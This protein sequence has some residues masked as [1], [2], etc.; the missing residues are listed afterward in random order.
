MTIAPP[1]SIPIKYANDSGN[2][3]LSGTAPIVVLGPNGAGKTR[4]ATQMA[5]WNNA[6]LIP[7][8]RN[9]ALPTDVVMRALEQG[10]RE[11]TNHLNQQKSTPWA[12]SSEINE[13]FSKLMAEDSAAAIR[14]RDLYAKDKAALP[15]VTKLMRLQEVWT[16]L[17]AGRHIDFAGY[18]PKVRS[19]Y[20]SPS[21]EYLA[22]RMS[23]G[24]RV[25]LYLAGRVLDSDKKIIIVDEPE[26]HFHS[27]LATRFWTEMEAMRGDCRF[28]YVTHDL[29]FA[30]SR[31]DATF[32]VVMP[33]AAPQ[34]VR[35]ASELPKEVSESL[36]AA[37][38]FSIHARRVVF[39]EGIEGRSWD[40]RL[41]SSWFVGP[42][43]VVIPVESCE[44]VVKCT[45]VF[46]ESS[47]VVGVQAIGVVDRDYWP[48]EFLQ[49]L[50]SQVR[51]LP[52][53]EVEN[54]FCISGVFA[55]VADCSISRSLNVSVGDVNI[56]SRKGSTCSTCPRT[57]RR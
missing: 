48:V 34:I 33:K 8:L 47:L 18:S 25:A 31:K 12:L 7:A 44:N 13:L 29:P 26:V 2:A 20:G 30:L 22:Q 16:R 56:S 41:Y 3:P 11:L 57:W 38:S 50:P 19:D 36:L 32:L 45:A 51:P 55:A 24:E 27:R 40:Q 4:H 42:E 15:E 39:C 52:V 53:H 35:L 21:G 54:L 14:F 10:R 5:N 1:G 46:A 6:D 49:A 28:V 17:F 43:T 37:A 9:I 23:D